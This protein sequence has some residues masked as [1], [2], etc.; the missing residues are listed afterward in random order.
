MRKELS[1]L[2]SLPAGGYD[3]DEQMNDVRRE[4]ASQR[5][6]RK[7]TADATKRS[8]EEERREASAPEGWERGAQRYPMLGNIFDAW[9]TA[10][11]DAVETA[12]VTDAAGAAGAEARRVT[13]HGGGMDA[14][15]RA[16]L[17]SGAQ[18]VAAAARELRDKESH[19]T[20]V[21]A[22]LN[23]TTSEPCPISFVPLAPDDPKIVTR[24]RPTRADIAGQKARF[25]AAEEAA[26]SGQGG[27]NAGSSSNDADHGG[28]N[29]GGCGTTS[30]EDVCP[31]CFN[32]RTPV[33]RAQ[34]PRFHFL[35]VLRSR[36]VR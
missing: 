36:D 8:A 9:A 34:P 33:S 17:E 12:D 20:C 16:A 28:V 2:Y 1:R 26:K 3:S 6:K 5:G 27:M 21:L 25:R 15:A 10:K 22:A 14:G 19:C 4:Q 29:G 30:T 7:R 13:G 23:P 35:N 32:E 24:S 18:A 11:E 31:I